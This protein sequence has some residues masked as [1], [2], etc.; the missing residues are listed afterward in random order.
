MYTDFV[1]NVTISLPEEVLE[2]HRQKAMEHKMSLNKWLRMQLAESVAIPSS[3]PTESIL[4]VIREVGPAPK[5]WSWN[6][7]ELYDE[8]FYDRGLK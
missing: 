8:A 3:S 5:S 2:A 1:R 4:S 7:A 6:R